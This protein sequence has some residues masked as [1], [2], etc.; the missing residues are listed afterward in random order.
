MNRNPGRA[1]RFFLLAALLIVPFLASGPH[2]ASADDPVWQ[3]QYFNNPDLAGTSLFTRADS[4]IS[5]DWGTGGPAPGFPVDNFSV[6]WSRNVD[7]RQDTYR[8]YANHDDG[9]RIFLDGNLI[10]DRWVD[11]GNNDSVQVAVSG[12][13]HNLRVEYF[14]RWGNAHIHVWWTSTSPQVGNLVTCVFP[15]PTSSWLKVYQQMSDGSWRDIKPEGYGAMSPD[16]HLKIDGLPIDSYFGSGGNPYRVELFA[17]GSMV[18]AAGNM[19]GEPPFLLLPNTDNHTPW[20]CGNMP[21][22]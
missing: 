14:E 21:N 13:T 9:V 18:A 5:F 1:L 22:P 8:F 7:F 12:G 15:P 2:I 16:G 17:A 3:G 19:A 10:M 6:R 11:G 20:Q 4:Q